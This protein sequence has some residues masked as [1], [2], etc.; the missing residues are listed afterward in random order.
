M[1]NESGEKRIDRRVIK[2]KQAILEA[3]NRMLLK[4]PYDKITISALAREADIDRKTFYLHYD[5][6]ENLLEDIME[7]KIRE[8]VESVDED[9][10]QSYPDYEDM[11]ERERERF[12]ADETFRLLS[13]INHVF[14]RTIM[15]NHA[16]LPN[17]S[18]DTMLSV[19]RKT[20]LK[21]MLQQPIAQ[22]APA[23][24]MLDVYASFILG[25][26]VGAYRLVLDSDNDHTI[27][28]IS[29]TVEEISLICIMAILA[30]EHPKT[31]G[32][33]HG[34]GQTC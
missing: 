15:T 32:D 26:A 5:S 6:I 17:L 12:R 24:S 4:M 29:D 16:K 3:F 14:H 1:D 11:G 10:K 20:L 21:V 13:K 31:V 18:V 34:S 30:K 23:D 2:T 33:K 9:I 27:E 28:E 25:G 22:D 19:L 7:D 8:V